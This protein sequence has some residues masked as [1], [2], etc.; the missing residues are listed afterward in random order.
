MEFLK[1]LALVFTKKV[2]DTSP[3][4]KVD[5]VDLAKVVRTAVYVGLASGLTYFAQGVTP[6]MIGVK[7]LVVLPLISAVIEF[8][9]KAVKDNS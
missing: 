9:N 2:E 7:G 5:S 3:K 1:N 8:L 6:D 4:G